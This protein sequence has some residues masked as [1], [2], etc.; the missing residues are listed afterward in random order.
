MI[1][2]EEIFPKHKWI[3]KWYLFRNKDIYFIRLNRSAKTEKW[4][5]RLID[6]EYVKNINFKFKLNTFD[7]FYYDLAFDNMDSFYQCIKESRTLRGVQELYNNNDI[8]LIFKKSFSEKLARF[9]YLNYILNQL[10]DRYFGK[11]LIFIPSIGINV[12]CKTDNCEIYYYLYFYKRAKSI[13][14]DVF[15]TNRIRFPI[16]AIVLSYFATGKRK[17]KIFVSSFGFLFWICL[18]RVKTLV[19][20]QVHNTSF[21][22]YAIMIISSR[23]QFA[24]KIQK[25]DF[26]I[27]NKTIKKEDVIFLSYKKLKKKNEH[28]MKDNELNYLDYVDKFISIEEIRKILPLWFS[29]ATS[30]F[31]EDNLVLDTGLRAMYFYARWKSLIKKIKIQNLITHGDFGQQSIARNIILEQEGCTTYYYLDSVNFGHFLTPSDKNIIYKHSNFGFLY[32]DYFIAW[33]EASSAYFRASQNKIKNYLNF[34]CLWAQHLRLIEQR[35]IISN[36]RDKLYNRGYKKTMK[37][38]S[39]FDSGLHDDFVTTY[40]DGIKFLRGI[41]RLLDDLPNIFIVLKEKKSRSNHE[42]MSYQFLDILKLYTK[43]ENNPRCHCIKKWENSS[44]TIAFSDLTISF[45]FTSTTFEAL[46]VGKKGLWYDATDKFRDTFYDTIPNLVCHD[47]KE[48]LERTKS[49]L[50]MPENEY[51]V[52]LEKYIKGKVEDYLDGNAITRFRHLLADNKNS[53]F[54]LKDSRLGFIGCENDKS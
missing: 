37:L 11:T 10:Q 23:R 8:E 29:V 42:K 1:I 9:Y 20:N 3:I 39:V 36:F 2:F 16:W 49:L 25:V 46:A 15:N 48:L 7:G 30:F 27:D 40:E 13:S 35:K 14:A 54:P 4:L 26:L 28:Y 33:N 24:N 52:Y 53:T 38:I 31:R 12:F 44:E 17:L 51:S 22:R 5:Q 32:Y 21:Y 43:L 6:E 18:I 45:P 47:Y 50:N 19:N 34:G 41:L